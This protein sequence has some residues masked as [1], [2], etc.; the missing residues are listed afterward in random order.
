MLQQLKRN[1]SSVKTSTGTRPNATLNST[2]SCRGNSS[3]QG[4]F[5][6]LDTQNDLFRQ[7]DSSDNSDI[8]DDGDE[9]GGK[10]K[11]PT[12]KNLMSERKRRKKLNERLYSLR[13][14]VPNISKMDKASIVSDAITHVRDLQKKVTEIQA[15]IVDL[16][17]QKEGVATGGS[18]A[19]DPRRNK[20]TVR[21]QK[22]IKQEHRLLELEVSQMEEHI[23]HL[24]IHCKKSPGV[25]VQLT[26]ALEALQLEIL[27]ANLSSVDDHI[28]N[29][30]VVEVKNGPCM[31]TEELRNM[32]L[33]MVQKFGFFFC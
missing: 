14:L 5:E 9:V 22:R 30:A 7:F 13:A 19:E 8:M 18:G 24:R 20:S 23:Y 27:N 1:P 2:T 26:R 25:L 6:M 32:A 31:H 11:A 17:S 4:R 12:S 16:E 29:T 15:D 28:L 3:S 21:H 33:A 10:R